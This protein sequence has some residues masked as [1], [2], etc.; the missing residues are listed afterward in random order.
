MKDLRYCTALE[1]IDSYFD[2]LSHAVT[3]IRCSLI[4]KASS[5]FPSLPTAASSVVAMCDRY[6]RLLYEFGLY[7]CRRSLWQYLSPNRS[8]F[9]F[10]VSRCYSLQVSSGCWQSA[11]HRLTSF[12]SIAIREIFRVVASLSETYV[13]FGESKS[14]EYSGQVLCNERHIFLLPFKWPSF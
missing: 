1:C 9:I 8:W 5:R 4:L 13:L 7:T 6:V 2:L 12:S 3:H 11:D 10:V 14:Q